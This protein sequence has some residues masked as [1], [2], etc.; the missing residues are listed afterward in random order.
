MTQI[1]CTAKLCKRNFD[2]LC[3]ADIILIEDVEEKENV[4][5]K[6]QDFMVCKNYEESD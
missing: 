1:F 2:G 3:T 4:K 6:E 5:F